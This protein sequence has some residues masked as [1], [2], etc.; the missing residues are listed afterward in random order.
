MLRAMGYMVTIVFFLSVYVTVLA[1]AIEQVSSAIQAESAPGI[2]FGLID[3]ALFVG[4]PLIL[5][6]GTLVLMFVIATG[7]RGTSR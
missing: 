4:L 3:T 6:G 1:P 2:S 5:L 7:L